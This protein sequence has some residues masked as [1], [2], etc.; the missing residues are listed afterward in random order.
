[1]KK[2]KIAVTGG[3]GSGKTAVINII[4]QMGYNVCSAD[5]AYSEI[6]KRE[7]FKNKLNSEFG[8]V[9][10]A[11]GN[12]NRKMLADIVFNDDN[13]LNR[14]NEI[15]H[16]AITQE[17]ALHMD[18][19]ADKTV[20]AEVPLLFE[21]GF[22]KY[23]DEVIV[24]YR[25]IEQRIR[26]IKE[27]DRLPYEKILKRIASQYNYD[28]LNKKEYIIVENNTSV[29]DLKEKVKVILSELKA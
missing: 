5:K 4:K 19:C 28:N 10:D 7:S 26:A 24:V 25:P 21:T 17:L 8:N 12:L 16:P 18:S 9:I 15:T 29:E 14:L 20:F 2:R 13:K 23:F 1:M 3:I 27:R 6:L 22:E 11:K